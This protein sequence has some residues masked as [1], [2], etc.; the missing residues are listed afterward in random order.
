MV[1][2]AIFEIMVYMYL[3][4]RNLYIAHAVNA[5][6]CSCIAHVVTLSFSQ[7][8]QVGLP[9]MGSTGHATRKV[10][11]NVMTRNLGAKMNWAA[12]RGSKTG[13]EGYRHIVFG[14]AGA[15]TVSS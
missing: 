4:C 8:Q 9:T 11:R 3:K 2:R 6:N 5:C 13:L 12:Q 7:A 1:C 15:L 14:I 10:M